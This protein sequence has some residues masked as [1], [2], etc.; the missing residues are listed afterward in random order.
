MRAADRVRALS[1]PASARQVT[2]GRHHCRMLSLRPM[3]SFSRRIVVGS[4]LAVAAGCGG[5]PL[6]LSGDGGSGGQGRHVAFDASPDVTPCRGLDEAACTATPGCTAGTCPSCYGNTTFQYC[7]HAGVDAPPTCTTTPPCAVPE[8]NGLDE[9]SCKGTSGCQAQSCQV[10]SG[11]APTYAGCTTP[12]ALLACPAEACVTAECAILDEA[13]CKTRNDCEPDYC[14]GGEVYAG[15]GAAG[16]AFTCMTSCPAPP[17]CSGL[18]E[19]MCKSRSDCHPGYC[20]CPGEQMF[21][22]CL[23]S[24]E[25]VACG[26]YSCPNMPASCAGVD[27]LGCNARPWCTPVQCPDCKGGQLYAGCAAVG[28][29]G[30]GCGP[31]PQPVSCN[32]L[33]ETSC[34][35]NLEKSF[36]AA[37]PAAQA[38][39]ANGA[40]QCQKTVPTLSIGCPSPICLV[41][42]NDDSA[43]A[44]IE[45]EWN[46]LGCAELRGY[47]CVDGCRVPTAGLCSAQ[48]G[49]SVCDPSP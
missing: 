30:V 8:C 16:A 10:C 21:T 6:Q 9:A 25:A 17:A 15:C 35:E 18:D 5:H 11:A 46:Q 27:Q 31:C 33:D 39:D 37:L 3:N 43:L 14:C 20:G 32:G 29:A 40:G 12:G 1:R 13:A 2:P 44:P 22:S 19:T 48:N 7:Y 34:C 49:M 4:V 47:T 28:G 23:A 24:N 38:C 36:Y 42:V 41:A 45:S 26:A